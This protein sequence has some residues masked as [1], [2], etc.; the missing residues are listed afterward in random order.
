MQFADERP[1]ATLP[2][3]GATTAAC[4]HCGL[5]VPAALVEPEA[6]EQYCCS[7]CRAVR[8]TLLQSGLGDYYDLRARFDDGANR[9]PARGSRRSYATFDREVFLAEHVTVVEGTAR[10]ELL[11]EGVRCAACVWLVEKL[12]RC[13]PGVLSTELRLRDARLSLVYDP[14]RVA[15]S[16]VAARLDALGYPVHPARGTS[17]EDLG[18]R[19]ER[20]LLVDLGV[21]AVCAGNA[22][23]VAFALYSGQAG[24]AGQGSDL[25]P[26]HAALF[27]WTGLV[28]GWVS[29][30]WPGRRFL[31]G[32]L[33]AAR[34]RVA[35][36]DV[37]ISIALVAGALAGTWNTVA[38][39]GE[40]Y[41]DSLTVL[42]FLL[43][44]GRYV[45]ARQQR[46]ATDSVNLTRALTPVGCLVVRERDGVEVTEEVTLREVTAGDLVLVRS[47]EPLPADGVVERGASRIDRAL[48][49]GESEPVT[50]GVGDAV[51]AGSQNV[52]GALHVRVSDVG[53]ASRIGRL[54]GLVQQGL[55]EKP[56]IER[57]TDRIAGWFVVIVTTLS[58]G[59][60]AAWCALSSVG[61]AVDHT[62]ALLIVA[63]PCALGLATPLTLAVAVG[64]AAR[65]GLLVKDSAV[66]ERL[67]R[68]G[69]LLLDKTG[70]I[71]RGAPALVDWVGDR[72]LRGAV[73]ALEARS[74]HPIA[75]ALCKA[76][77][78]DAVVGV[79][80][81][82]VRELLDGGV[83]GQVGGDTV[84][85]GSLEHLAA[86]GAAPLPELRREAVALEARG[87][88]VVGV[89]RNGR[90]AAIL[91]LVDA[92]RDDAQ[93]S[94]AALRARGFVPEVLSGDVQGAVARVAREVGLEADQA[95][96]S[97]E[98]EGK[99]ARVRE[100]AAR[101]EPVVMVGDGVNDAAA[102]AA[103]DVGVAVHGGAEAS[104]A[105][106]DA[107][108]ARPG[109]T[110]L[111][112]LVDLSRR[113]VATIRRNLAL[114]LV[115]NGVAVTLAMA[116]Y[117][118]PLTAAILMP[119]SSA[120]V[121]ALALV[122][123]HGG[124]RPRPPEVTPCL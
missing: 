36:L 55:T 123:I 121:L 9:E 58:L 112:E 64:R 115:Y 31:L 71:T 85:V 80:A 19:S 41:F 62:V 104:L 100:L 14:A 83:V 6:D 103:A 59:T 79:H 24:A 114:S 32:A 43:L 44:A 53:A 97:I 66:F 78:A 82:D 21:A 94:I 120:S 105:A 107:Y 38:A 63:C 27:R 29:L 33:G 42:V 49:T 108:S 93:A 47:G 116:G 74:Q 70:T 101:G 48:L 2:A 67:A 35:N 20:R 40:S 111:V 73:A 95:R 34:A 75:R 57:F 118:E 51:H 4:A 3:Q 8:A 91:G 7:G 122:S 96:G 50:V 69:R 54:M 110:P 89:A 52:G 106:A 23:L 17:Q 16:E 72:G 99:L 1:R 92:P 37:P 86:H 117:V 98:P 90:C 39:R 84:R 45:Q 25:A 28:L 113:T 81:A 30:L 11:L 46:F 88:T 12:P 109:L 65:Q 119:L 56:P 10:V 13:M 61:V 102:L 60:F 77:E 68:G 22:M 26:D 18:K 15:L 87:R 124:R 76:L 5:H